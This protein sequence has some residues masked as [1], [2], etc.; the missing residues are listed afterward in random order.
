V[1]KHLEAADTGIKMAGHESNPFLNI[2]WLATSTDG[3]NSQC[4]I[5]D[6]RNQSQPY[7]PHMRYLLN[8][9]DALQ[10]HMRK[11]HKLGNSLTGT[12]YH[13]YYQN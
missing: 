2:A 5:I 11:V 9:R 1:A 4:P 10:A 6:S 13:T 3:P 8:K 12:D 7:Q